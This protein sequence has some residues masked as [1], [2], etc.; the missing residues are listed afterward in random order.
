MIRK[1][2]RLMTSAAA[3]LAVLAALLV[4]IPL[5]S[6][7]SAAENV[8]EFVT[9]VDASGNLTKESKP[10][11]RN[12]RKSTKAMKA[13]QETMSLRMIS[14]FRATGILLAPE[15]RSPTALRAKGIP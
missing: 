1:K 12:S 15:S 13:L 10:F 11:T 5:M 2:T 14:L 8:F 7:K 6:T 3:L 9:G 4:A